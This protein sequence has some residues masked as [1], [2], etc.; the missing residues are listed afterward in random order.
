MLTGLIWV[1]PSRRCP[2]HPTSLLPISIRKISPG[3]MGFSLKHRAF[4]KLCFLKKHNTNHVKS[5]RNYPRV[6]QPSLPQSCRF[7][8]AQNDIWAMATGNE[9][10]KAGLLAYW[11]LQPSKY[12]NNHGNWAI[13]FEGEK[14]VDQGIY[15][16]KR[17]VN[18]LRILISR[19]LRILDD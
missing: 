9:W 14:K 17:V 13:M 7:F 11:I 18:V 3:L 4:A 8:I 5:P 1:S 2:D 19:D 15:L 12:F 16:W 10:K 6:C